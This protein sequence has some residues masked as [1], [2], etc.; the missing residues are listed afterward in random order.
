MKCC[1]LDHLLLSHKP[2]EIGE[3]QLAIYHD[4]DDKDILLRFG[5]PF[6]SPKSA[7][8]PKSEIS[9]NFSTR[10]LKVV[11]M[12]EVAPAASW[13]SLSA[14]NFYNVLTFNHRSTSPS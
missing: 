7:S 2:A 13:L 6:V 11:E 14:E 8:A 4:N 12:R 9:V 1:Y 10:I 5:L 3:I